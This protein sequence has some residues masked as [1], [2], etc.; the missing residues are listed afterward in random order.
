MTRAGLFWSARHSKP[1]TGGLT[2]PVWILSVL[3]ILSR[4]ARNADILKFS[5]ASTR[6]TV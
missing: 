1:P 6:W 4:M 3:V 2:G 5:L